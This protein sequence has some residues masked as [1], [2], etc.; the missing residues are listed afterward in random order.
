MVKSHNSTF[1]KAITMT[2]LL[3][4]GG[5]CTEGDNKETRQTQGTQNNRHSVGY[6]TDKANVIR[7]HLT[8]LELQTLE[9][10]EI[11]SRPRIIDLASKPFDNVRSF[12]MNARLYGAKV[13]LTIYGITPSQLDEILTNHAENIEELDW[14]YHSA[15]ATPTDTDDEETPQNTAWT[16]PDEDDDDEDE[17]E[18]PTGWSTWGGDDHS[19]TSGIARYRVRRAAARGRDPLRLDDLRIN[20]GQKAELDPLRHLLINPNSEPFVPV[21]ANDDQDNEKMTQTVLKW[22]ATLIKDEKSDSN[23]SVIEQVKS[24]QPQALV[25]LFCRG[26]T[27]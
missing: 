18:T 23:T 14:P 10:R 22:T 2:A 6:Y 8:L 15:S 25:K 16:T 19:D 3:A 7:Q 4:N 11:L 9:R 21:A 13:R 27:A 26:I 17:E 12:L 5:I 24:V 20:L 1:L